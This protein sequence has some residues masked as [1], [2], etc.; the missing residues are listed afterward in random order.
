VPR[1]AKEGVFPSHEKLKV[2][3][4]KIASMEEMDSEDGRVERKRRLVVVIV[5]LVV[6]SKGF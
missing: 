4:S 1:R 2:R 5:A 3:M 6:G